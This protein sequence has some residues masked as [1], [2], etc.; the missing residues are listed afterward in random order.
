MSDESTYGLV[1]AFDTDDPE[2]V[3]GFQVGIIWGATEHGAWEGMVEGANTEMVMRIAEARGMRFVAEP[4]G[5]VEVD[6]RMVD[7]GWFQVRIAP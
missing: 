4:A 1:L 6:G 3:R 2:F 7:S 5:E